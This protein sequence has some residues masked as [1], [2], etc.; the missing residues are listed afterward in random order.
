MPEQC[1]IPFKILV[2]GFAHMNGGRTGKVN[3]FNELNTIKLIKSERC[4]DEMIKL[5]NEYYC[6]SYLMDHRIISYGYIIY[7]MSKKL[8]SEYIG[9]DSKKI[10]DI[11]KSGIDITEEIYIPIIGYTGDTAISG[12]IRHD[13]FLNV[14]I[15]L[16]ECTGFNEDDIN[17]RSDNHIHIND[18]YE[19]GKKFRNKKIILYHIS[20]KYRDINELYEYVNKFDD[21]LKSKIELFY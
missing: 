9:Y 6:K 16:M 11:K 17:V 8:K 14:P 12:V 10:I 1:I 4:M 7:R 20:P 21:D 2:S 19:N 3:I 15:L 13:D 5:T 18:I